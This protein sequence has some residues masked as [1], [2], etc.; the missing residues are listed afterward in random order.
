[1]SELKLQ[2]VSSE[3]VE[4]LVVLANQ[5]GMTLDEYHQQ[6][7]SLWINFTK[8]SNGALPDVLPFLANNLS[9]GL[10]LTEAAAVATEPKNSD[11]P[12]TTNIKTNAS[13][14]EH[15]L[16]MPNVGSDSDFERLQDD[17]SRVDDVFN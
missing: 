17:S 6:V 4:E 2:P 14:I 13:F 1:M 15:L 16:A 10:A 12:D 11:Y 5:A 9:K 3:T 7:L 8:L